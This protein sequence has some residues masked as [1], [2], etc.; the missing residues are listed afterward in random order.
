MKVSMML[1]LRA[2]VQLSVGGAGMARA[3]TLA[4]ADYRVL[5]LIGDGALTGGLAYEGLNNAGASQEPLI[6]LLNDNGM[7]IGQNV[8]GV[9]SHLA[10]I[11]T[12]P[13][14][15]PVQK[16]L[17]QHDAPSSRWQGRVSRRPQG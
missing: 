13:G 2:C 5:A 16:M 4:G 8:G 11:R 15:Y 14:Y 12:R 17:S 1:L 3:R 6:I 7:S 10:R 9:A